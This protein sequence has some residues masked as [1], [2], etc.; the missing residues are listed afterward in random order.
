MMQEQG[1]G[2]V[3]RGGLG[4]LR[5]RWLLLPLYLSGL[6]LGLLQTWPLL[7]PIAR[8]AL[9]SPLLERLASGGADALANLAI[10][11]I[12]QFMVYVGL[13]LLA[14]LLLVLLLNLLYQ[15]FSGGIMALWDGRYGFWGGCAH[16]F[17]SFVAL[18]LILGALSVI[19]LV[20]AALL[21]SLI[22][23]VGALVLALV[24]LQLLNLLGEYARAF[25]VARDRR[26][27]VLLFGWAVAFC[28]RHP[29]TLLLGALGVLLHIACALLAGEIVGALGGML[30]AVLLQQLLA[31][32]W[33]LV[34]LL[35]LAW[36]LRYVQLYDAPRAEAPAPLLG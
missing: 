14:A 10:A 5:Q 20:G 8:G 25:A 29:G 24:L 7:G 19:V 18:G 17:L 3:L 23:A 21:M 28:A 16:F 30:V 1:F 12:E 11:D 2:E 36:A 22:G 9:F 32:A 26:N 27:P 4:Y 31:L 33:L 6:L 13:W 34:K 35:R 15:F